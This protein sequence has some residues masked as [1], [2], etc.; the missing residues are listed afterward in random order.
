MG[1]VYLA[2]PVVLIAALAGIAWHF[3]RTLDA[4][5]A[6]ILA[7][8]TGAPEPSRYLQPAETFDLYP[9]VLP[10]EDITGAWAAERE[11][12]GI[13]VSDEEMAVQ[14]RMWAAEV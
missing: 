4:R 13:P 5:I 12:M 1:I 8:G 11:R 7:A 10:S 9:V 2:V 6:R 14:R 3:Y